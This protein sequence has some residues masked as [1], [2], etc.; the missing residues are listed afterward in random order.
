MCVCT[1]ICTS[2]IIHI[3]YIV[4]TNY[5]VNFFRDWLRVIENISPD[6]HS[7]YLVQFIKGRY[8]R[9]RTSPSKLLNGV[10]RWDSGQNCGRDLKEE[11]CFQ[12][13]TCNTRQNVS[14]QGRGEGWGLLF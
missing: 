8:C 13:Y 1:R 11:W 12:K 4:K 5:V 2:V 9:N 3:V 10:V 14:E 7:K 6:S